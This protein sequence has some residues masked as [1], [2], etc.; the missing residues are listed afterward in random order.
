MIYGGERRI[1]MDPVTTGA[2]EAVPMAELLK[3]GTDLFT[4]T[5]KSLGS[6]ITTISSNPILLLGFLMALIGFVIGIT[7]RLM[8]LS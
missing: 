1:G 8:N 6:I 2:P 5:M 7:R 4:W 3:G